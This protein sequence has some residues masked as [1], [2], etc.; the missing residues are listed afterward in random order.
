M[1]QTHRIVIFGNSGSG[2]S[3]LAAQLA[4]RHGLPSLDLDTIAWEP[5]ARAPTRRPPAASG[6][7]IAAF[8]AAHPQWVIEGC[9]ADLLALVLPHA[10]EVIFLNPGTATCVANCRNRPWE[11]HKYATPEAQDANLGMLLGWIARYEEREDEFSLAAHRRLFDRFGG[12]K[13]EYVSND[14]PDPDPS[15]PPRSPR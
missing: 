1:T 5:E 13:V 12:P 4:A 3:V 9:Y 15:T 10:S 6:R 7:L 2:K 11:P 14:R 8:G